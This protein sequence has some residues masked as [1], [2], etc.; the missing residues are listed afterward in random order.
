MVGQTQPTKKPL[1]WVAIKLDSKSPIVVLEVNYNK[2][3]TEIVGWYTLDNRNLERIKRQA[4]KNGGE[5]IML[6]PMD[7]VESLPTPLNGLSS[8]GNITEN[9]VNNQRNGVIN[10]T[11]RFKGIVKSRLCRNLLSCTIQEQSF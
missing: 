11:R 7:K 5:L 9:S 6:S 4:N 8:D 3:N 10:N 2:D 1:H